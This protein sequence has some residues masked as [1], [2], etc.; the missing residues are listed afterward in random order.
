VAKGGAGLIEQVSFYMATLGLQLA[1]VFSAAAR[2]LRNPPSI[3]A[4][5]PES[6]P[7]S[8]ATPWP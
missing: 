7:G 4:R 2:Y 5:P 8:A 1:F 6:D 3:P